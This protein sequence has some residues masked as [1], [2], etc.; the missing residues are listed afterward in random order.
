MFLKSKP[1]KRGRKSAQW[2]AGAWNRDA[3][4]KPPRSTGWV[5]GH[6]SQEALLTQVDEIRVF[7]VAVGRREML[8]VTMALHVLRLMDHDKKE[9]VVIADAQVLA[10]LREA[11]GDPYPRMITQSGAIDE[12]TV[13]TLKGAVLLTAGVVEPTLSRLLPHVPWNTIRV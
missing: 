10:E 6:R 12:N 3:R 7:E 11:V 1:Q 13:A 5:P 2:D 4:Q 8:G 9:V